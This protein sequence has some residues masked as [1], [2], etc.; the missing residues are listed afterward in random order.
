V[1]HVAKFSAVLVFGIAVA[2]AGVAGAQSGQNTISVPVSGLQTSAGSVRCGLYDSA[3]TFRK[4]GQEAMGSVVSI[5]G[6]SATCVFKGVAPGTYAIAAFHA[7]KGE[8]ELSYGLFGKP[9]QGY[10]FSRNPAS[11]FGPPSFSAASF[12]YKGGAVSVPITLS[13]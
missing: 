8:T 9:K 7:S 2:F 1:D 11:L 6:T 5:K 13:Y 12:V 3:Q 4:T 10:G